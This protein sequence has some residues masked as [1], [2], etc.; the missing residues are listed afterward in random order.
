MKKALA[1]NDTIEYQWLTRSYFLKSGHN[2]MI[3]PSIQYCP[4][5][6]NA[7]YKLSLHAGYDEA[8]P[9]PESDELDWIS[10]TEVEAFQRRFLAKYKG[11][12]Q[13]EEY[14]SGHEEGYLATSFRRSRFT[15]DRSDI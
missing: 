15:R 7:L 1:Y 2:Q 10:E 5:C 9:Q 13:S 14:C 11:K 12:E 3:S 4:F 6:G 8:L